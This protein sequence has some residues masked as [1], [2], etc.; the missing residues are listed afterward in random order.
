MKLPE[1]EMHPL[2]LAI[3][4]F[5][6][7][8][9]IALT[10]YKLA[11]PANRNLTLDIGLLLLLLI[12]N[13]CEGLLPDPLLPGGYAT[14]QTIAYG[15]GFLAAAYL[16]YYVSKGFGLYTLKFHAKTG[17]IFC[18]MLPFLVF[19]IVLFQTKNLK[20]AELVL[21]APTLYG[22]FLLGKVIQGIYLK[23]NRSLNSKNAVEEIIIL[24]SCLLPWVGLPVI[25][26]YNLPQPIEV[27]ATNTGFLLLLAFHVKQTILQLRAENLSPAIVTDQHLLT[28]EP[29]P[30]TETTNI[31]ER[32]LFNASKYSLTNRETEIVQHLYKGWTYK[33]VAD[34]LFISERTVGKHIQNIF[35]KMD[36]S[37]RYELVH[38]LG[39]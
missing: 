10:A 15:S 23:Y 39:A 16:P 7:I 4:S 32:I 33:Q 36:I 29:I 2:I 26:W 5:E 20:T 19:T 9:T 28:T 34:T 21:L 18:L 13:T 24:G 3:I 22:I 6:I 14:Q 37:N 30:V 31:T 12:C 35:E 27:A 25:T 1:S 11:R 17:A 8:L 38:K